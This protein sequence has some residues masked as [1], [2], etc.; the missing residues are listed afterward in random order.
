MS[1]WSWRSDPK[2]LCFR[3]SGLA[4]CET[5]YFL[6]CGD[7]VLADRRDAINRIDGGLL[8]IGPLD[9]RV[10]F[11]GCHQPGVST[12]QPAGCRVCALARHLVEERQAYVPNAERYGGVPRRPLD[13]RHHT[14]YDRLYAAGVVFREDVRF[15]PSE[16][17]RDVAVAWGT[18]F[19]RALDGITGLYPG[20]AVR[21]ESGDQCLDVR[22]SFHPY[23]RDLLPCHQPAAVFLSR[24]SVC[25]F[26]LFSGLFSGVLWSFR[27][28]NPSLAQRLQPAGGFAPGP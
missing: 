2:N 12:G 15:L 9:A 10:H 23:F 14:G 8:A 17:E 27:S 28:P 1:C 25:A 7:A 24:I 3:L 6:R 16:L 21:P 13:C 22:L 5:E 19:E 11:V 20:P 18:L 26:D 4:V